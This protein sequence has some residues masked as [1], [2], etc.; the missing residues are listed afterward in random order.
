MPGAPVSGGPSTPL[1]INT[2]SAYPPPTAGELESA[3]LVG[4]KASHDEARALRYLLQETARKLVPQHRVNGCLWWLARGAEAVEVHYSPAQ[5]R[6]RYRQLAVCGSVWACPVCSAHVGEE[7]AG[8]IREALAKHTAAGGSAAFATFT[9]SHAHEDSLETVLAGFLAAF[10]S[11]TSKPSYARLRGRWGVLGFVRVLEVT[12]GRNGWHVHVHALYLLRDPQDEAAVARLEG[13]LYPLW[14]AAAAKH[15]LSMDRR[16]GLQV[17]PA[18][19]TVEEYLAKFGRGPRWDIAREIAKG[20]LKQ[21]RSLAGLKHLTPWELLAAARAGDKRCGV[22]FREYVER[23]T[24]RAQLYW[25]P[26]YASQLRGAT[27]SDEA[28]A[29]GYAESQLAGEIPSPVW[30]SVKRA[31]GRVRVLELV[32]LAGGE[33]GLAAAY[34][35]GV[36]A[37]FPPYVRRDLLRVPAELRS[38]LDQLRHDQA[39]RNRWRPLPAGPGDRDVGAP[40]QVAESA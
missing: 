23:F 13:E 20:H 21:G 18:Y 30:E 27:R 11:L 22:L 10:R 19:G 37:E 36:V 12:Y 32:E 25:S 9:V 8:E 40:D 28:I 26:G 38:A 4:K 6:A 31:G 1:V 33:W 24:G 16:F 3:V 14:E 34:L 29:E 17:K 15:G 2:E 7:R 39:E 5:E 35:A